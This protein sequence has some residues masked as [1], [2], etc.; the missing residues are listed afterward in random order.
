MKSQPL[1][2]KP[3]YLKAF[4]LLEVEWN[5]VEGDLFLLFRQVCG[6]DFHGRTRCFSHYKTIERA[7]S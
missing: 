1:A 3:E 7:G 2:Y 4:G 5:R 6:A